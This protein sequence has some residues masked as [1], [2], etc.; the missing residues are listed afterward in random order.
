MLYNKDWG[1]AKT[2]PTTDPLSLDDFIAWL[3]TKDPN[4]SYHFTDVS[5]CLL[6]QWVKHL[7]PNAFSSHADNNSYVYWV[8]GKRVDFRFTTLGRVA[9]AGTFGGALFYAKRYQGQK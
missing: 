8:H 7:D 9:A 6:A 1:K 4:Q 5:Q 3:E 2:V